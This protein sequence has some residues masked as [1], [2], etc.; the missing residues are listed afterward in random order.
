[1]VKTLK[2][3]RGEAAAIVIGVVALCTVLVWMFKPRMI[4]GESRR[5]KASTESTA[6]VETATAAVDAAASQRA[7][8]AAASV[9]KIAEANSTAPASAEKDFIGREAPVALANLPAPDPQALLEAERRRVAVMEGRLAEASKLY[10]AAMR[11]SAESAKELADLRANLAT[12]QAERRS[13]DAAIAEAAAA[14]LALERQRNQF[15]VALVIAVCAWLYVKFTHLSP[16]AMAEAVQDIRGGKVDPIVAL[17][18]VAT[19]LQQ[20]YVK[21]LTKL[22][23]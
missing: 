11:S 22:K 6:Q 5:A 19:R 2:S 7:A 13:A 12:A 9:V 18:G 17:D 23:S 16:G 15:V 14:N 8:A 20:R 10:E 21:L 4:H 1:M 3:Q